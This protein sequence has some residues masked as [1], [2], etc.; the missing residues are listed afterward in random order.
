MAL[1]LQLQL[2]STVTGTSP[3]M[4][5]SFLMT[6]RIM[7]EPEAQSGQESQQVVDK[8]TTCYETDWALLEP[9]EE[10]C[11]TIVHDMDKNEA[12]IKLEEARYN[13]RN[14]RGYRSDRG[15]A[16]AKKASRRIWQVKAP[17]MWSVEW[18]NLPGN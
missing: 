10:V 18:D 7:S 17:D 12:N 11:D 3:C 15:H 16:R 1:K 8:L 5:T 14:S 2:G 9:P 6:P 13:K 4:P